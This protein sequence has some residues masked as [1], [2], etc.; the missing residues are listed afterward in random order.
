V[1]IKVLISFL[2]ALVPAAVWLW[3]LVKDQRNK[4]TAFFMFFGGVLAV[5]LMF[6]FLWV[7]KFVDAFEPVS[8][9]FLFENFGE[10]F[11]SWFALGWFWLQKVNPLPIIYGSLGV[12]AVTYFFV[13]ALEEVFKQFLVR[14]SDSKS[15]LIYDVSSSI[16]YSLTAGLGFAFA[17]NVFYFYNI[18]QHLGG[19][20]LLPAVLFRGTFTTVMHMCCSGIWGYYYGRGKFCIQFVQQDR[21]LKKQMILSRFISW[22]TSMPLVQAFREGMILKGLILSMALHGFFNVW[23]ETNQTLYAMLSVIAAFALLLYLVKSKEENLVLVNEIDTRRISS[24][25]KRDEE[26]V[27]EYVGEL[28]NKGEFSQVIEVCERLLERDPDNLVVKL[29]QAKAHDKKKLKEYIGNL[30]S[31]KS[32]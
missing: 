20:V 26:T 23:L 9:V 30:I 22:I 24:M 17:E 18:W 16:N 12:I 21:W 19:D 6:G 11:V 32:V 15:L 25:A 14:Y 1:S 4:K 31:R 27:I 7:L 2:L 10:E 13:A 5:F 29:F 28:Y 8:S 3:F